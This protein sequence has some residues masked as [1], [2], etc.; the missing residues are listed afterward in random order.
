MLLIRYCKLNDCECNNDIRNASYNVPIE[1][2]DKEGNTKIIYKDKDS[3]CF[4][5]CTTSICKYETFI[6]KGE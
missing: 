4:V 6:T 2:K 1:V 5:F 3:C